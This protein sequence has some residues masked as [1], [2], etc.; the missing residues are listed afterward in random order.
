MTN[1]DGLTIELLER[2]G[3]TGGQTATTQV[4]ALLTRGYGHICL[5]VANVAALNDKLI[6]L[7]AKQAMP[8]GPS[9]EPGVTFSFVAD[10]EGNLIEII[11]RKGPIA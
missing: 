6:A 10:P 3:A 2:Q 4:E 7:G 11:D 8:V 5:R 1:D 9:P